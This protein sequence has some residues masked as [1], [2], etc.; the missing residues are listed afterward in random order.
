MRIIVVAVAV[1][2]SAAQLS[3][4]AEA[5][6]REPQGWAAAHC[7]ADA[8]RAR[9]FYVDETQLEG[10][11]AL[12]SVERECKA[13]VAAAAEPQP[14]NVYERPWTVFCS[15]AGLRDRHPNVHS[16]LLL[17]LYSECT[18]ALQ[19]AADAEQELRPCRYLS[20]SE[21][22][23]ARGCGARAS[24]PAPDERWLEV[25]RLVDELFHAGFIARTGNGPWPTVRRCDVRGCNLVEVDARWAGTYAVLEQKNGP[26]FAKI[27]RTAGRFVEVAT[28]QLTTLVY[29]GACSSPSAAA[30]P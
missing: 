13:A 30:G 21:C 26:W 15:G 27:E 6:E 10:L 20:V 11:F 3:G 29:Y 8:V 24:A 9:A 22:D 23:P 28:R 1:A 12:A 7:S 19:A 16:D 18:G 4:L 17:D 25:P 5:Q 14:Q 2:S